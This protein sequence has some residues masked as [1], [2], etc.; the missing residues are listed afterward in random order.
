MKRN[1]KYVYSATGEKLRVIYQTAVPNIS[2]AMGSSRELAPSEIQFT[3]STE[4]LLGG[5]LT[6]KNGRID[7]YQFD[8]GYC[9]AAKVSNSSQDNFTF[10]YYNRDHLGNVR[11]V[12]GVYVSVFPYK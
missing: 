1:R 3:D 11:Q 4:Y 9:K 10:Y 8:E 12:T 5:L 6:L 2:V 7:K